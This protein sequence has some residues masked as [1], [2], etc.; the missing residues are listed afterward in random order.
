MNLAE[1][2]AV[3]AGPQTKQPPVSLSSQMASDASLSSSMA[4]DAAEHAPPPSTNLGLTTGL[5]EGAMALGS[6]AVASLAAGGLGLYRHFVD[7][8]EWSDDPSLVRATGDQ[9]IKDEQ[10][11]MMKRLTFQPTSTVGK[12]ITSGVGWAAS[13]LDDLS[14][15]ASGFLA[16][17]AQ[18]AGASPEAAAAIHTV[19]HAAALALLP[20]LG[21]EAAGAAVG[22]LRNIA[23]AGGDVLSGM[24]GSGAPAP[25]YD[26]S[27]E[28]AADTAPY[29]AGGSSAAT[30]AG[31]MATASPDVAAQVAAQIADAQARYGPDWKAHFDPDALDR[32]LN[33]DSLGQA[34][35]A[36]P[37]RL[38]A[39]QGMRD[40]VAIS[41][42]MN[43]RG[44]A[45]EMA[46][47]YDWQD[48]NMADHLRGI[49]DNTAPDVT[50]TTPTEHGQTLIQEYKN[51]AAPRQAE[52]DSDWNAIRSQSG[53]APIFDA[54]AMLADAQTALKAKLLSSQD[55]GGQLAELMDAARQRGG[56]SADGYNAFRQNLGQIARQGG[57]EGKAASVVIDATNKS[58]LLPEASTFRD[59]VNG[60]LAKGR[61][62]HGDLEADP[63]YDAAVNDTVSAN[64][65]VKKF[66]TGPSA[67]VEN[68][69]RMATNL[70][71]SD[72]GSQTMRAAVVDQLRENAGLDDQYN[73]NFAAK[74][75]NKQLAAIGQ[76]AGPIFGNGEMA[77]LQSLGDY[78]RDATFRPKGDFV[79]TANTVPAAASMIGRVGGLAGGAVQGAANL[80]LPG[81]HLGTIGGELL[82]N[83]AARVAAASQELENAKFVQQSLRPGVIK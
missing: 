80:A 73:G 13:K 79:S 3:D 32:H 6:G 65:F 48:Q 52:I 37:G 9:S 61:A 15:W 81:L 20:K 55:P 53:D 22:G 42:E 71:G 4:A 62:L 60:A 26:L 17:A 69:T 31:R 47:F 29:A 18:K 40:P 27:P 51:L 5:G 74:T 33:A 21:T 44:T 50:T 2:M 14:G 59:Q 76:R 8:K 11:A 1:E 68:V 57:T 7:G 54:N 83:R 72:I 82:R 25:L 64:D 77:T 67:K 24:R 49:R 41:N 23:S 36:A 19:G 66:L 10:D 56:L 35:G 38:T 34:T 12:G 75:F 16:D 58:D 45:T 39:G 63:A 70:N 46:K 30:V 43:N 78:A 28:A